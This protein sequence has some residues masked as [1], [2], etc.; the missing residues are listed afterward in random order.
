M[1]PRTVGVYSSEGGISGHRP[2]GDLRRASLLSDRYPT[3]L[4]VLLN[5]GDFPTPLGKTFSSV[6]SG[7]SVTRRFLGQPMVPRARPCT[8]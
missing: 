3:K 8:V 5:S 6:P 4:R 7:F 2:C 1:R